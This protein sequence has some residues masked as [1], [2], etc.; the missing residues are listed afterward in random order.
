MYYPLRSGDKVIIGSDARV[1]QICNS[2]NGFFF[3]FVH[4]MEEGGVIHHFM[5]W[6]HVG[7]LAFFSQGE[8]EKHIATQPEQALDCAYDPCEHCFTGLYK[9]CL[10]CIFRKG[11]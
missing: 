1:T 5:S 7:I 4:E 9:D 2:S 3:Q 8:L 10:E 11:E 6:K